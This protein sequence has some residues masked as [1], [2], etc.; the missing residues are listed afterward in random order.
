MLKALALV[1]L[2]YAY[3]SGPPY[4]PGRDIIDAEFGV[5][6]PFKV[7]QNENNFY[8]FL[9]L[10]SLE[11]WEYKPICKYFV[12][13]IYKISTSDWEWIGIIPPDADC[14]DREF[15]RDVVVAWNMPLIALSFNELDADWLYRKLRKLEKCSKQNRENF[16]KVLKEK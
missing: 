14:R 1:S 9:V 4:V 11:K 15:V 3:D 8:Y 6:K 2:L 5:L 10:D 13:M 12:L 7:F 16:R